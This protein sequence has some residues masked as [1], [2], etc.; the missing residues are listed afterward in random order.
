M[1]NAAYRAETLSPFDLQGTEEHLS[2][3]A[4]QGWR[5]ESIGHVFW[6][7]RRAEPA[8]IRYAVTCPPAAGENG[9][10]DNRLYFED[11]C[12]AAGWEKAADWAA[13]QIYANEREVPT[14]LETD[15]ALRLDV[16]HQSM[17]RTFLRERRDNLLFNAIL[18]LLRLAE[19]V[20]SPHDFFLS[21]ISIGVT[22]A[23]LLLVLMNFAAILEYHSW[24]RRSLRSVERGGGPA[25]VPRSYRVLGRLS[26]IL[27]VLLVLALVLMLFLPDELLR[28]PQLV[29][30]T[31][32]VFAGIALCYVL[33]RFSPRWDAKWRSFD[34]QTRTAIVILSF[35]AFLVVASG[36]AEALRLSEWPPAVPSYT[37]NGEEWDQDPQ[38]LPLTIE[39]LTGQP[40]PHVR[41]TVRSGGRTVFASKT[42]YTENAAQEDGT[43]AY[44][45]YSIMDIPNKAIYQAVLNGLLGN[46]AALEY[47]PD[48]PSPWGAEAVYQLRYKDGR[49]TGEWLICWPGRIIALYTSGIPFD[50]E[51]SAE[52]RSRLSER[53]AAK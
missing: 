5:L 40:W 11:L 34:W 39:D 44:L 17:R 14:P 6:K 19:L 47:Q 35:L 37:W 22:L 49:S 15:E 1:K 23:C 29:F 21:N 51:Q 27:L 9:G 3:M 50:S 46:P 7:Y 20:T 2:A 53:E 10:L 30:S 26:S 18:L 16:V 32:G 42:F 28:A 38:A 45:N 36:L 48:S 43:E 33:K 31:L 12:A 13:L 52:V 8:N 41:R 24:R 4:A 25:A